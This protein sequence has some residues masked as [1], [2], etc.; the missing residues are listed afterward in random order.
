MFGWRLRSRSNDD[1]EHHVDHSST[2]RADESIGETT[3]YG[4]FGYSPEVVGR[5]IAHDG[6]GEEMSAKGVRALPLFQGGSE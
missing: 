3:R 6:K 5:L 1:E 4:R 2:G